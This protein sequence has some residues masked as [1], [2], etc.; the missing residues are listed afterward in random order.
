MPEGQPTTP[1][2]APEAPPSGQNVTKPDALPWQNSFKSFGLAVKETARTGKAEH[3]RKWLWDE[4]AA[5]KRGH[6]V[7]CVL[8]SVIFYFG[9]SCGVDAS[10]GKIS[11]QEGTID[12]LTRQHTDDQHSILQVT[13]EAREQNRQKDQI[14]SDLKTEKA[15]LQNQLSVFSHLPPDTLALVSNLL[16]MQSNGIIT[17]AQMRESLTN[18][19]SGI[20]EEKP[21]FGLSVDFNPVS[22]GQVIPM[23]TNRTFSFMAPNLSHVTATGMTLEFYCSLAESNIAA[24]GWNPEPIGGSFSHYRLVADHPSPGIFPVGSLNSSFIGF[25]VTVSTNVTGLI[26]ITV[27][28]FSDRSTNQIFR[29]LFRFER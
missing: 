19:L 8:L 10:K 26:P 24:P 9:H 28:V 27:S 17:A 5:L 4:L 12:T 16:V 7:I 11:K 2:A 6:V 21:W 22:D 29:L 18:A 1:P 14:I 23:G 20:V 25:P 13:G 15:S 3:W